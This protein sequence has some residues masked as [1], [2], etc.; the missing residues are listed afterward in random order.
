MNKSKYA[1]MTRWKDR[2]T[3]DVTAP[4]INGWANNNRTC[5]ST[6]TNGEEEKKRTTAVVQSLLTLNLI[7]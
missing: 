7:P 5:S 2:N 4:S 1:W 3:I 6:G